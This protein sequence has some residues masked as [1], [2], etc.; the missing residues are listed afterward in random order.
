MTCPVAGSV[1]LKIV[2][3]VSAEKCAASEELREDPHCSV[4]RTVLV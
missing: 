4:C 2:I 3:C 1:E